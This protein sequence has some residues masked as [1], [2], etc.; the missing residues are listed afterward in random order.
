[1]NPIDTLHTHR[2]S[3]TKSE[4]EIYH[5]IIKEPYQVIRGSIDRIAEKSSTSKAAV[6]R[7][8]KKIG[9]EGYAQFRFEMS[10]YLLS[11]NKEQDS[12]TNKDDLEMITNQYADFT[13]MMTSTTSLEQ[14]NK[15][16]DL[17]MKANRIKIFGYNRTGFSA[18]QFRYRAAK[19][20]L[21]CE[22]I[23]DTVVMEDV[24]YSLKK[25]DLLF[26]IS[27]T[28][29]LP[30]YSSIASYAK[31][32]G[33]DVLILTMN[34]KCPIAGYGNQVI[35]LPYISR[36]QQDSFLDDQPIMFIAVEVLLSQLAL[37]MTD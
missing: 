26:I 7:L 34:P 29:S 32:V 11:A 21:D 25:G 36:S 20:P 27:I 16:T 13:K 9:Y 6:V 12:S 4:L 2:D 8:C 18:L 1:M 33:A 35:Y 22:A 23:T 30:L 28:G 10:R 37:K 17:L 5:F 3:Y 19:L 31:T 15:A 24:G 14:F